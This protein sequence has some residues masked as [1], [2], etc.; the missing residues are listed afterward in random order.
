MAYTNHTGLQDLWRGLFQRDKAHRHRSR[1]EEL[2]S[3]GCTCDFLSNGWYGVHF[4][5]YNF[6]KKHVLFL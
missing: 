3:G 5:V 2:V 4:L 6:C 1:P